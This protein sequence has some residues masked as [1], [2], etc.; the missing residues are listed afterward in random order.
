METGIVEDV[1]IEIAAQKTE[2]AI[3]EIV[4]VGMPDAGGAAY[5]IEPEDGGDDDDKDNEP[6]VLT[7]HGVV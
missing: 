1:G 4:F 5:G 6:A 2:G 3:D 7:F